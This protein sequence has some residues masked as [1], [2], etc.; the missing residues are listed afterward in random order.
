MTA[1][2]TT[3]HTCTL[4]VLALQLLGLAGRA[5]GEQVSADTRIA[6][7]GEFLGNS[8]ML[9]AAFCSGW[10]IFRLLSLAA[11]NASSPSSAMQLWSMGAWQRLG[12]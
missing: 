2:T 11:V 12:Q 9:F 8:Q 1:I 10:P 3:G 5:A 6:A 4:G 7:A